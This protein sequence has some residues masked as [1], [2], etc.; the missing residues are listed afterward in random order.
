MTAG[1]NGGPSLASRSWPLRTSWVNVRCMHDARSQVIP[2]ETVSIE[3]KNGPYI[4]IGCIMKDA[5][6]QKTRNLLAKLP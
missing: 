2:V 5:P 1:I 4:S 3:P 6:L